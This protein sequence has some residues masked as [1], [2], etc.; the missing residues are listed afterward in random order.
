MIDMKRG[1]GVQYN[2][3]T[4]LVLEVSFPQ[5]KGRLEFEIF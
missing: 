2:M 4:C 1:G 3:L 5:R